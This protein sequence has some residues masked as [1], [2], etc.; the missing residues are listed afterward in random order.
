M[1]WGWMSRNRS[2]SGCR[3]SQSSPRTK[4]SDRTSDGKLL[5]VSWVIWVGSSSSLAVLAR[6][7]R[8]TP[9]VPIPVRG[10]KSESCWFSTRRNP[11]SGSTWGLSPTNWTGRT[12]SRMS[13]V[14]SVLA[15]PATAFWST[16]SGSGAPRF[17]HAV[18]MSS[19]NE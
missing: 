10:S 2:R 9:L 1:F 14:A 7:M 17:T 19:L 16:G 15:M 8:V 6:P 18:I 12:C 4:P 11:F 3:C 5:Q 13:M